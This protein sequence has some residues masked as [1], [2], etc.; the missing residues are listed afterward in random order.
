MPA[1]VHRA[2]MPCAFL[3]LPCPYLRAN[4]FCAR[5][6]CFLC[7]HRFESSVSCVRSTRWVYTGA[8]THLGTCVPLL[9][10]IQQSLG[11]DTSQ[12]HLCT[13]LE[14]CWWL[15]SHHPPLPMPKPPTL[16]HNV[17][18]VLFH[19]P[20][21]LGGD[22]PPQSWARGVDTDMVARYGR[23]W[24]TSCSPLPSSCTAE[25]SQ[26][27]F[28]PHHTLVC[29]HPPPHTHTLHTACQRTL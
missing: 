4:S 14:L 10:D 2:R 19:R 15:C 21:P 1:R 12:W 28:H 22:F 11:A 13:Y 26:L 27:S 29:N 5:L 25:T 8:L 9:C 17:P 3:Y 7:L 18:R 20:R 23:L 16:G 6:P 24:L